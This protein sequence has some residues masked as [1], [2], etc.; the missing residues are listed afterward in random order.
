VN[1]AR[2]LGPAIFAG[3]A[4]L[5]NVWVFFVGPLIGA[6]LSACVWKCLGKE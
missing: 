3:G 6:A 2:S 4:A 1:P 5:A